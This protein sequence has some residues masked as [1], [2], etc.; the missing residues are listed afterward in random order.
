MDHYDSVREDFIEEME[1]GLISREKGEELVYALEGTGLE[2][3]SIKADAGFIYPSIEMEL[4]YI[5]HLYQDMEAED[6]AENL[7]G[8]FD[9]VVRLPKETVEQ[10]DNVILYPVNYEKYHKQLE[11]KDI[12]YL[13]VGDI[14]VTFQNYYEI[15]KTYYRSDVTNEHLEKWGLTPEELYELTRNRKLEN[16]ETRVESVK[17]SVNERLGMGIGL[18]ELA[19]ESP[20]REVFNVYGLNGIGPVFYPEVMQQIADKLGNEL[21]IV[22]SGTYTAFVHSAKAFEPKSLLEGLNNMNMMHRE[23]GNNRYILSGQI[24]AYDAQTQK[25]TLAEGMSLDKKRPKEMGR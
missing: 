21:L 20:D 17:D 22:P 13:L 5:E 23:D 19:P 16:M 14:A 18:M 10:V 7:L 6:M 11:E 9:H 8:S 3:F 12:A 25:L 2:S 15:E 4:I 1:T 24:Y